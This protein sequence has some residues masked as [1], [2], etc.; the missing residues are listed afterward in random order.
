MQTPVNP[1]HLASLLTEKKYNA[2][3]SKMLVEGFCNGFDIGYCGPQIRQDTSCNLP[4]KEGDSAQLWEKLMA[5]VAK[6]RV[7]G[8]FSNI[9]YNSYTQS[10]I[11][12]VPKKGNKT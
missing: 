8:P 12:L 7:A 3:K 1:N 9:P 5:E 4:F 10:L 6:H 2:E 11:G